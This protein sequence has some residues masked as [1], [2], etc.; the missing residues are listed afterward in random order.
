MMRKMFS[1]YV[2]DDFFHHLYKVLAFADKKTTHILT[3]NN[4]K[5][6]FRIKV[7]RFLEQSHNF[8]LH[9][10]RLN[11]TC[12]LSF[13]CVRLKIKGFLRP[14]QIPQNH[15]RNKIL[16]KSDFWLR[17]AAVWEVI[18]RILVSYVIAFDSNV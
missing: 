2:L 15:A 13:F 8:L 16:N 9:Y 17:A 10:T 7:K 14:N 12:F 3:T 5:K 6:V 4:I 18:C 11:L 1:V